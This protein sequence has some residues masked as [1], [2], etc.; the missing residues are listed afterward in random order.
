MAR[1]FSCS[2][3]GKWQAT[4]ELPAKRAPVRILANDCEDLVEANRLTVIGRLT[5]PII[6]KPRAVIDFMSQVWNLEGRMEGRVLGLDKFQVNF[7]SE[8]DLTQ[9]L[10]KGPYHFKRWMLLL[11]RWE[12]TV[13]DS[14][15]SMISFHVRIHGIP[16]QYWS[17]GTILTIGSQLGKCTV[18]DVKEAKIWVEVDGLNPLVMKLEIELPTDEVTEVEF[19]YIKIEKHCFTCF[20]LFHEESDCPH[21]PLH[22]PPPKDRTLGITQSLALQRIE[23][24][25][26][27]HDERRGYRRTDDS[28]QFSRNSNVNFSQRD[29]VPERNFHSRGNDQSLMSLAQRSNSGYHRT[30]AP[31]SQYRVVEK[32]RLRSGSSSP[33]PNTAPSPT[34]AEVAGIDPIIHSGGIQ[35]AP[36]P[37]E[38]SPVRNIKD[39][40]GVQEDKGDSRPR[41]SRRESL[42]PRSL[43][44]RL[45]KASDGTDRTQSGSRERR[46][47]LERLAETNKSRDSTSRRPPSFESGILQIEETTEK[48]STY[49]AQV[50]VIKPASE[51]NRVPASRR[52]RDTN[53]SSIR[54]RQP[55]PVAPQSKVVSKR[56]VSSRK[57]VTRSPLQTLV[58]RK[59]TTGHSSTLTR[60]RLVVEKDPNLPC[61]KAVTSKQ[62][63]KTGPQDTV[64]IPGNAA[65]DVTSG[66]CGTGGIYCDNA[67]ISLPNFS[68]AHHHVSSALMAE[69]IAVHRAVS[70]A[71]YS[72]V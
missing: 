48:G 50:E 20:S 5:N 56:R 43:K 67:V 46:S 60:R 19:E 33:Q 65:W 12:P 16:L 62:R 57:R 41:S 24:E 21:R 35:H 27:R 1:R 51:Q 15:P 18:K 66:R 63:K 36:T 6:Q 72:N 29:R 37:M 22:A 71:V 26:R 2:E 14:F 68:E 32:S 7:N 9:F 70:L 61:N 53:T 38:T 54:S 25:K 3:K 13:S 39:R 42:T 34:G 30:V 58:S 59:L 64:F 23:A 10:D 49:N 31:S 17:K 47:A 40:L 44:D 8:E 69:A 55:I 52:I 4:T 11:Q 28:R 45:G